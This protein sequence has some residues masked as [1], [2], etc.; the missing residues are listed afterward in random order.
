MPKANLPEIYSPDPREIINKN[1]NQLEQHAQRL[2]P[3]GY[4]PHH[5]SYDE[6]FNRSVVFEGLPLPEGVDED[7]GP[8][9]IIAERLNIFQ[10]GV[11]YLW[12]LYVLPRMEEAFIRHKQIEKEDKIKPILVGTMCIRMKD[13]SKQYYYV[14][15][16]ERDGKEGYRNVDIVENKLVTQGSKTQHEYITTQITSMPWYVGYADPWKNGLITTHDLLK[17]MKSQNGF[18]VGNN[19]IT[20]S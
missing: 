12:Y 1:T 9:E 14:R 3:E 18:A 20:T 19:S 8:A 6:G 15:F 16:V 17:H 10:K 2:N 13:D 7:K 5:Y 11:F 4:S